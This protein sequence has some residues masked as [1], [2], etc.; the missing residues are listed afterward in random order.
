MVTQLEQG[1]RPENFQ[2]FIRHGDNNFSVSL[3]MNNAKDLVSA[4][5]QAEKILKANNID[6]FT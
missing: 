1:K 2:N 6:T 4:C 3:I 5:F